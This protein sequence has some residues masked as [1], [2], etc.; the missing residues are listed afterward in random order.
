MLTELILAAWSRFVSFLV[1]LSGL[2]RL[3]NSLGNY[4][5]MIR[6]RGRQVEER[7]DKKS[8]SSRR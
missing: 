5:N 3:W 4:L 7:D 1:R 6:Q 2:K 8:Q